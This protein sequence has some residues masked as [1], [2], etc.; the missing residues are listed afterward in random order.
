MANVNAPFGARPLR[1]QGGV[2]Y[3]GQFHKY[4]IPSGDGTAL[5]IGDFVTTAGVGTGQTINGETLLDVT[6]AA[7][8]DVI[9]GV[10]VGFHPD[11][12]DSTVHRAAS[13]QRVVFVC[14]D[15]NMLFLIQE[16]S[17]GTPLT[18]N[19]LG[20]NINFVVGAGSA[21]TGLSGTT[22]NNGT[23]AVTNTLDLKL[24]EF[25]NS[26]DNEIGVAAQ[27][28]VVRINRHRYVDQVAGV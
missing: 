1:T 20:L 24:M 3:S 7:T 17:T 25:D 9:T 6:R 10:V 23:E 18:A 11:T 4:S 12:R 19:D 14:D 16:V 27:R 2:P 8:G 21:V 13:T 15:P 28:W 5:F 26:P 22:L